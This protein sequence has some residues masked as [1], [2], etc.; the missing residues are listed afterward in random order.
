[1]TAHTLIETE[2]RTEDPTER[3]AARLAQH[4]TPLERARMAVRAAAAL[5]R[6]PSDTRQVFYVGLLVNRRTYPAFLARFTADDEGARLLRERPCI[7]S[8]H[9]DFDALRAL[10]AGTLGR[11]YVRLLDDHGLD[12]DLFRSP[13]GLPEVPAYVS[14]RMRQVH[15]VWHVLTGYPT[16]VAG[17][18]ALQAFTWAQTGM[19]SAMW[20]AVVGSARYGWRDRRVVRRAIDGYRRGRRARF[21]A[22]VRLEDRFSRPLDEVRR[23][24]GL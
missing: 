9:V 10:P 4:G 23:E 7:D 14:Q 8:R 13:P 12:P 16:D 18:I 21:L 24:L 2:T 1:M 17:E 5:I 22:P 15:D 6:D 3:E 11:E 19:A 20:I